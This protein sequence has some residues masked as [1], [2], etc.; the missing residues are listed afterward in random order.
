M[1]TD[2]PDRLD[3]LGGL[4]PAGPSQQLLAVDDLGGGERLRQERAPTPG[5]G[6]S[7]ATVRAVAAPSMPW[8]TFKKLIALKEM[9]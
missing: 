9:P 2:G 6:A 1:P 5:S 3:L 7:V 4:D 8:S